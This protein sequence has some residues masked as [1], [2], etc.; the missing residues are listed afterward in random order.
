MK[1]NIALI[2]GFLGLALAGF[3]IWDH[4]HT[5]MKIGFVNSQRLM[6]GFQPAYRVEKELAEENE[7]FKAKLK[8]LDDSLKSYMDSMTVKYDKANPEQQRAIQNRLAAK[9]QEINNLERAHG[10]K[11]EETRRVRMESV[12]NMINGFMSE[13]GKK[14]GYSILFGTVQGGNILYG[15][16]TAADVTHQVLDGLNERYK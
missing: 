11:M 16:G 7:K 5:G 6:T 2:I 4:H 12:Y 14:K 10:R 8:V 15:E 3:S 1:S 9:N 13:F